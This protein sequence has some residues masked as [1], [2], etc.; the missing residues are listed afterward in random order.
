MNIKTIAIAL[1]LSCICAAPADTFRHKETGEVFYGFRTNR[2]AGGKIQ[3][4]HA[5]EKKMMTIEEYQYD[6]TLDGNGRRDTVIRIPI[7]QAEA[8]ISKVVTDNLAETIVNAANAGPQFVVIDIDSPGGR[9][10]YI[11]TVATTIEQITYCPIVAFIAGGEYG[12]VYSAAALIALACDE[13]Y[14][15]PNASIGAVG[16][17]TGALTEDQF[18]SF[19]NLYCSDT[20]AAYAGYAMTLVKDERLRLIARALVDKSVSVIE[21]KDIDNKLAYVERQNRQPTQTIIRTLAEGVVASSSAEQEGG[22]K[23]ADIM[24]RVLLLPAEEAVRVGLVDKIASSIEEIARERGVPDARLIQM[25]EIETTIRRFEAA[26]RTLG[27]ALATIEQLEAYAERLQDQIVR[28]EEQIRTGTVT[29]EVSRVQPLTRRRRIDFPRRYDEFYGIDFGDTTI[30]RNITTRTTRPGRARRGTAETERIIADQPAASPDV[31]R[32]ELATVLRNLIAEYRR[33]I[34]LARRWPG[35]LPADL[36]VQ[37]LESNMASAA[38]LLDQLM[39]FPV[40]PPQQPAAEP[41]RR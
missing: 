17:M 1:V 2:R 28:V 18:S 23:P 40:L 24:G 15:A 29:R 10:E 26:R 30:G 13:I 5:E 14:I 7:R 35:A 6:I 25:G 9:G 39:R 38:A 16:P 41:P 4:Y 8:L 12:G 3:V 36:P 37:T 20:L 19:I 27:Q 31:L 32:N 22:P 21:V 33:T 11:R 34:T